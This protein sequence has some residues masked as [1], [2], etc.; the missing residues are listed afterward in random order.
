MPAPWPPYPLAIDV[1]WAL[2]DFTVENGAT[3]VVPGRHKF[4]R[5]PTAEEAGIAIL[6]LDAPAGLG[7]VNGASPC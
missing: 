4:H 5:N 3:R 7:F 1:G 6:P 2:D